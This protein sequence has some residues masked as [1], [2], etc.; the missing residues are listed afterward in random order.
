M[1]ILSSLNIGRLENKQVHS[2]AKQDVMFDALVLMND[3]QIRRLPIMEGSKIIGMISSLDVVE[4]IAE[5]PDRSV[6]DVS[7]KE[8]MRTNFPEVSPLATYRYIIKIMYETKFNSLPIIDKNIMTGAISEKDLINSEFIWADIP[9]HPISSLGMG[10]PLE[11][12]AKVETSASLWQ[13]CYEFTRTSREEIAMF[14]STVFNRLITP[15][16]VLCYIA[17]NIDKVDETVDFLASSTIGAINCPFTMIHNMPVMLSTVREEFSFH[18]RYEMLLMDE[19]TPKRVLTTRH[20]IEYLYS[21]L[22]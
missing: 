16:D 1:T 21:H 8:F 9:E 12:L 15:M 14:D 19:G 17:T 5:N 22:F 11:Q 18:D 13:A 2:L 10:D 6:L 3:F 4:A 20:L 7:V